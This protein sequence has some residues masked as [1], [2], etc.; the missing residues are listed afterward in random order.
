MVGAT[1]TVSLP[2]GAAVERYRIAERTLW[3]S[4]GLEPVERWIELSNPR[5]RIRIL[6]IGAGD[7]VLFIPG[8]GGTGPYW[9]PLVR[10]LQ[11]HRCIMIDRPG[12]GLSSP[13]DYTADAY[14]SLVVRILSGVLDAL[15]LDRVD[16]VGASIGA[17]W[18]LRLAQAEPSRVGRVVL[19]GGSPN[20]EV[21][22]P[23]FI[24][25]LR[26]PIGAVLVRVPMKAGMLRKQL[27]ALGHGAAVDRGAM[28]DFIAWRLA[29][30]RDTDSMRHERDMVKAITG[31]RGFKPG[32]TFDEGELNEM[33]RPT[34]MVFGTADPTGTAD[35]WRRFIAGLPNGELRLIN[36]AG[37]TPWWDAPS[38][39]AG[40]V[41]PFLIGRSA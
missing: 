1:Q 15:E 9:A 37:H 21:E 33:D 17:I 26:S 27:V 2:S 29:F 5:M 3:A 32:V 4:Y 35:I 18:A 28:E 13:I 8:T 10:E 7:P 38:E 6:E 12:W 36:D 23:T 22:I 24:K 11:G 16:V 30:Q 20:R 41:R 31:P 19:I 34:L 14:R 25:L 40:H 39:V